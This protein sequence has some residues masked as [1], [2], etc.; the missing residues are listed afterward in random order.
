MNGWSQTKQDRWERV[1]NAV[2]KI[3]HTTEC[4]TSRPWLKHYRGWIAYGPGT[5]EHNYLGF[6]R[7]NSRL[8]IP[9]KFKTAFS[10]I[11]A[12]NK[13]YPLTK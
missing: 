5:D 1:D 9:R 8:K 2:V 3:D 12:V 11:C 4:N 10:A 13:E 6:K 7:K